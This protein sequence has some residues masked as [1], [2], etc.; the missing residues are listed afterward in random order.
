MASSSRIAN[1]LPLEML[2]HWERQCPDRTYLRQTINRE[3]VDFTWGEVADEARRMVTA[4][5]H[6]GLVAGD[7]VALLSKN[8]AQWFIADLAMQMGQYV[9][10]PIYPTANVDTIEYVLRHSEAKAIFVGKLDDW[11]SQEAG[12]PADLLRIAFPY[13]TMPASHQWD[14]LLEAHEP[15]PDSPVQAPDSLLSLVYTSGSTGK[16]KGAMLSVERY[17]WSCEKL[18]ETVSLSQADRG[19]SYLPLAHITERVYIYGGSLYGG[20]TIAFPESL[21][22]FIEDVKRCRPTVF[23][24]VPRL[25]AMFRIKIHEKLPQNKLALLLKIPLISGLIKR[26]LQKGLGLD[27][28]RVLG[29]GS[30]PVSPA[31]LEWYLSIGLKVTEAWGMTENHAYSTINYPFRADKIG[32]VGKAGI[33]VTIKISD[34]GEILCRCEGMMLGYYKDPEHSAEAIDAEGWLHTGDMGKLDKE[35]YLTITGRMKDVFKT[36]KGKYVAPVP[37][38]GLLGQEPIIEQLCVIGY[39][40]PQPIALVQLAESAMKGNREEVNARLEAARVRV[41][42]QLESHA[43]IRGI[44]VVKTPW[45]IENG[46]LTPTMKIKRHLLE[47]KYAQVGDRWPSS[48]VVVWEE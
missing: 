19:F 22:T 21:D 11:K 24:S 39:G 42:D 38:E 36:A 48:Q 37:I 31:L 27:Q 14:D 1:K 47:Q 23:I 2:Y 43:K 7:K 34:E 12:V 5:R 16:P 8:C 6:L 28:A 17:A 29:C 18:V 30:A 35:G 44:L 46:V 9:S 25:W 3:Y 33:G 32:T 20:A 10:V 45:N 15:I 13:D 26:K 4:L 41:N 40:M